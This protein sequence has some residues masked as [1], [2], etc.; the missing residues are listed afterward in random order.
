LASSLAV[1]KMPQLKLEVTCLA[2]GVQLKEELKTEV[3]L[4]EL[5]KDLSLVL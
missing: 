2:F 1:V 3:G 5:G 4:A